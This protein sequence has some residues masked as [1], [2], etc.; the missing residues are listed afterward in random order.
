MG[1]VLGN[2]LGTLRNSVLGQLSREEKTDSGLDLARSDGGLL[3]VTGKTA[4]LGGNTLEDILDEGVHDLHSLLGDTSVGVNLLQ[5]T[6]DVGG[7]G[8]IVAL[9][10]PLLII[11]SSGLLDSLLGLVLLLSRLGGSGGLLGG[12][13]EVVVVVGCRTEVFVLMV[14]VV[15]V[16]WRSRC[17]DVE[18][19]NWI[20]VKS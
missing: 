6:V 9:L 3:V 13:L 10:P 14:V 1:L 5:H 4:R 20:F 16:R 15:E 18:V 17:D 8:S 7:V 11:I 2:S 12:H 19:F